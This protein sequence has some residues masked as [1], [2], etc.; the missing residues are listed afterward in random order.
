MRIIDLSVPLRNYSMEGQDQEIRYVDHRE[1]ARRLAYIFGVQPQSIPVPGVHQS[2]EYL[3]L[4]SHAGTHVDAPSHYGPGRDGKIGRNIDEV[5]LEW[6]FSDGVWLDFAHVPPDS[7]IGVDDIKAD[8]AQIGYTLK[9]LD[10]VMIRTGADR[11][12]DDKLYREK[13]AGLTAEACHWLLDQGIKLIGTDSV[14]LDQ[15]HRIMTERLN[16]GETAAWFPVHYVGRDREYIMIEKL[17]N[18]DKLPRRFG[19]KVAAFPVRIERGSGGWCRA[20]AI[21]ED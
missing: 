19:F 11:Y 15:P 16:A 1:F 12:I 20:V 6:C 17:A 8:L 21:F 3:N 9:P 13:G 10:I 7:A 18:L 2:F 14:T 4:S 5:P